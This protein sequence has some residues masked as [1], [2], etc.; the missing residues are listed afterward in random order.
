MNR[1]TPLMKVA[2]NWIRGH[3]FRASILVVVL[4]FTAPWPARAI[5]FDPCCALLIAG[6]SSIQSALTK[7]IGGGLDQILSIDRAMEQFQLTVVWPR[8]LI[9]QA[10]SV[11][12]I[13]Q[14]NFSQIQ[15]LMKIPVNSAT[16]PVAQISPTS[17]PRSRPGS[18]RSDVWLWRSRPVSRLR[19]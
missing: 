1:L 16:L 5:G 6:L 3:R 2:S 14:A 13:L 15:T 11:V 7:V 8:N 12:G 9:D 18:H 17:V 19:Q 4:V 10:R